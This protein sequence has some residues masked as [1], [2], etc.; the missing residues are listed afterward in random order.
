M[1]PKVFKLSKENASFFFEEFVPGE[2][3]GRIF[4]VSRVDYSKQSTIQKI[5]VFSTPDFGKVLAMDGMIQLNER[6]EFTYHEMIVHVPLFAHK[7]PEAVLVIGGGDGGAVREVL[8]H[9]SVKRVD[10]VEIDP[11]VIKACKEFLPSTA[12][13]LI[14]PRV[15]IFNEDGKNFIARKNEEYDVIVID[16]TDPYKGAGGSLFTAEFYG[17]CS[18]ALKDGGILSVQA[19]NPVYDSKEMERCFGEIKKAFPIV[20]PY[21]AFV[22]MYPSGFWVF[23][24]ASKTVEPSFKGEESRVKSIDG[25]L[26][27]YNRKIHDSAFVLPTFLERL[28]G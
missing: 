22:P 5:D 21:T 25:S 11:E 3:V 16:S 20:R 18:S 2:N 14:D 24:Y 10:L 26:V 12:S 28:I 1:K 7:D 9:R 15:S 17:S 4:K 19:E 6:W 8:K 27:Y 23:A 13:K